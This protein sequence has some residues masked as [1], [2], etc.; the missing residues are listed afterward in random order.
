MN[1]H[2]KE[3]ARYQLW[4]DRQPAESGQS[5]PG[6]AGKDCNLPSA[7]DLSCYPLA[8]DE[9]ERFGDGAELLR[10]KRAQRMDDEE[11]EFD[12]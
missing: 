8:P 6:N 12:R 4:R 2:G 1:E 3:W 9:A 11:L 7:P 10:A 5:D